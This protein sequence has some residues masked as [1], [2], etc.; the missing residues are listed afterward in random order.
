MAR[1]LFLYVQGI[2]ACSIS[3]CRKY[4]YGYQ[5]TSYICTSQC[6]YNYTNNGYQ[7]KRLLLYFK[8]FDKLLRN[9]P[10]VTKLRTWLPVTFVLN[11][12]QATIEV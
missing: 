12:V 5:V 10:T 3:T 11:N 6:A 7:C 1:P 8:L 9:M 4:T 2:I